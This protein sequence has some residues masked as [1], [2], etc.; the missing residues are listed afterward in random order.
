[1]ENIFKNEIFR[2]PTH[3]G[4]TDVKSNWDVRFFDRYPYSAKE[5]PYWHLTSCNVLNESNVRFQGK[6]EKC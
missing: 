5:V 2:F 4:K 3:V 6:L 1:M